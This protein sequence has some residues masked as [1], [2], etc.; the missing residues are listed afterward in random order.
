MVFSNVL[1]IYLFLPLNLIIYHC[2]KSRTAK[3]IT[4][5]VF[6][7]IFY[8]W[9]EPLWIILL[10]FSSALD[11]YHGLLIEKNRG[12]KI[13]KLILFSSVVINLGLLIAFKYTPFIYENINMIFNVS[14][15][16]PKMSLPIGISFYTFQTL[17]YTVDVYKGEVKAQ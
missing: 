5:I 16:I 8:A 6:S 9:G 15:D 12:K 2:F 10:L 3:N 14:L 1:F 17:S 4:L 11:Y 13:T 7:L